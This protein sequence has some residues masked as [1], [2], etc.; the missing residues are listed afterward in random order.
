MVVEN[1]LDHAG[2]HGKS[3][4]SLYGIFPSTV[5]NL[6]IIQLTVFPSEH[7]TICS[8]ITD[9]QKTIIALAHVSYV[10]HIK[11]PNLYVMDIVAPIDT[12]KISRNEADN[13][14]EKSLKM[15]ER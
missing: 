6:C 7:T 14:K 10:E 2:K 13:L 5:N 3:D 4:N 11:A 1:D 9:V 15:C 12:G 8:T